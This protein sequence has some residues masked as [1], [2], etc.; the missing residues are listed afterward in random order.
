[1]S[2]ST[3][4]A[5]ALEAAGELDKA[6]EL[7]Q[8]VVASGYTPP[9]VVMLYGRM[10][11]RGKM[12][13]HA[14]T[15]IM[16]VLRGGG[17]SAVDESLLRLAAADLLDAAGR[18]DEAFAFATR[19]NNLR[20][21]AYDSAANE[22]TID[23]LIT[24]WT[25]RRMACLPKAAY[26]SDKPV[27]IVGMPRSG[28]SLVEQIVA[29]HPLVHGAGELDFL[30][31]VLS[32]AFGMLN[33]TEDDFPG[34][35]DGLSIA[36]ADGLAQIYLEPLIALNPAAA[37]ITD[38]MPLN[39]VHLG[40]IA[41]LLPDARVIHCRRDP[42]DTCLSCYMTPFNGGNDFKYTLSSLGHFYRQYERLMAHWKQV[43]DLPILDVSYEQVIA[44]PEG[45]SRKMIEF[46]DLPWDDR[47]LSFHETRRPVGTASVQQVRRPIYQSSVER[48]RHYEKY[49]G[50]LKSA[51]AGD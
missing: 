44:D 40:L 1:M 26:R 10:S 5:S 17:L 43:L 24:Y 8:Q 51:L 20:R 9:G 27:F 47:C 30:Y 7:I 35:L 18:Y 25:R 39:F 36:K 12:Q 19:A 41:L 33:S 11:R 49:L 31:R 14:L 22:A 16:S 2:A 38:K 32:G 28:T 23:R 13:E 48:F 15:L 42:L 50:P 21:V 45:Q 6:W 46:L 3:P 29:S 37:R 4:R 34:S